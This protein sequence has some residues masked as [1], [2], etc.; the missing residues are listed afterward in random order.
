LKFKNL[1]FLTQN[2]K[3]QKFSKKLKKIKIGQHENKIVLMSVF[4]LLTRNLKNSPMRKKQKQNDE[5]S[6]VIYA[7]NK[8]TL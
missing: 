2:D 3:T 5:K 6:V 4:R 7:K 8:I 1:A